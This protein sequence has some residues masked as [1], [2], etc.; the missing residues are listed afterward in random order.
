MSIKL[1]DI[2]NLQDL[3]NVKIRF[4]KE[5]D[6]EFDP[7]KHFKE[8]KQALLNGNFHNYS[9][10]SYRLGDLTIGFAR[11]SKDKWLLFDISRITKDLN[12]YNT[13]GYEY[14]TAKEYEKYFGRLIIEFQNKSQNLIR[15]AKS[16]I[17]DCKVSQILED[18]FDNDLFPGYENVDISW[19]DLSRV[20][21]KSTWKTALENQK[22][23]YL[24]ADTLTGKMYVGAAYGDKMIYGRW[25]SYMK[26][27]HG[28]NKELKTFSSE[29]I[30]NNFKYSILEIYKSTVNDNIIFKRESW[31]KKALQ[32]Q[33][34][35]F[36]YN[37]N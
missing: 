1:N 22:G 26:S 5:N 21:N 10:K 6:K 16:V 7:I 9:K 4:N 25:K 37:H 12:K 30:K 36:G 32:T 29:Y 31:W 15:L 34:W 23:I 8:N 24:I 3:S 18:T 13:V 19:K 27:G 35:K 20:I 33:I 11:I 17:E 2:L 14:E 28:G